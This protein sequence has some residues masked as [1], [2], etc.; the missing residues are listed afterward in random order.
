MRSPK[1]KKE[2]LIYCL[3]CPFTD[4]IHYI[5]KSTSGLFRP[6]SHLSKS[7]SREINEWVEDLSL[8]GY[9]PVICVLEDNIIIEELD[10]REKYWIQK[11]SKEGSLLLNKTLTYKEIIEIKKNKNLN[12]DTTKSLFMKEVSALLK[13]RRKLLHLTQPEL[14]SKLGIGLKWLRKIEAGENN[15]RFDYLEKLM[16]NFGIEIKLEKKN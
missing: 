8:L 10:N 9:V 11:F 4:D 13:S 15:V 3:K 1:I 12:D 2:N 7:H 14:C 16:N 6:A 5:G